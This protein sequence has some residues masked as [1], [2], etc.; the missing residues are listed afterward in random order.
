MKWIHGRAGQN[1][2]RLKGV[3]RT[4]ASTTAGP[5]ATGT[6]TGVT[7]ASTTSGPAAAGT[8]ATT[9]AGTTGTTT[10]G[11]NT[12]SLQHANADNDES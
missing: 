8:T 1:A 12:T 2:T 6:A 11:W 3:A 10:G 4:A 5:A 9:A 7:A